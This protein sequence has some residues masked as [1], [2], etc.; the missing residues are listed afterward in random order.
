[1]SRRN[2]VKVFGFLLGL[3]LLLGGCSRQYALEREL[4]QMANKVRLAVANADS[5]VSAEYDRLLKDLDDLYARAKSR[6]LG[7]AVLSLKMKLMIA[8]GDTVGARKLL[9]EV[10]EK[11][12]SKFYSNYFLL[13][14]RYRKFDEALEVLEEVEREF[15]DRGSV[16]AS[17]P[18]L[19][20]MVGVR[21]G[22]EALCDSAIKFYE[23]KVGGG[24]RDRVEGYQG[25]FFTYLLLGNKDEASR[26]LEK[27]IFD[28]EVPAPILSRAL[29]QEI[30]LL[31]RTGEL[32]RLHEILVKFE[33]KYT[34]RMD[35]ASK[36]RLSKLIA[37]VEKAISDSRENENTGVPDR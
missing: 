23:A 10:P 25:L 24:P 6:N 17:L 35:E 29:T 19:R 18:F 9:K 33:K 13:C 32:R 2:I 12:R 22:N 26:Y 4:Y 37:Q 20:C 30:V 3:G 34:S 28:P 16:K 1:M 31:S 27:M 15:G 14:L 21:S 11:Y 5:M 8:R 7:P 36:A